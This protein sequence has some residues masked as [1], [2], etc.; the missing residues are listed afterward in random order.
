MEKS[1]RRYNS[2]YIL[3]LLLLLTGCAETIVGTRAETRAG[4][5]TVTSNPSGATIHRTAGFGPY[6]LQWSKKPPFPFRRDSIGVMGT[7]PCSFR[8][9]WQ[10]EAV[11]AEWPDGIVSKT[12][13]SPRDFSGEKSF[14]FHFERPHPRLFKTSEV[15]TTHSSNGNIDSADKYTHNS[16]SLPSQTPA[17]YTQSW[18]VI[19]GISRYAHTDQ[20]GLNNLIF[21]DDDAKAFARSLL[22]LGW[23][24]SHIKLLINKDAS[25][26]NIE[27]A[28]ESWLTKARPND[29]VILF[30]AGHG[31][32]DPENQEK[33]YFATYDTDIFIPATGYRMDKV[34]TAL[35]EVKAKNVILL[36]DT[37]HAGKL[38]TRGCGSRGISIV[39]NINKMVR[40]RK[41]PKGW[42][43]MVGADTC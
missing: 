8:K 18:A 31:Y 41:V 19:V 40:E 13:F 22:N 7:T 2:A 21:A 39:P 38:I 28:L 23:N 16:Q 1:F 20:N 35:E 33:V 3:V 15:Q 26:R 30:W 25:K 10:V 4:T 43:F 36:A 37:C 5:I 32:P 11:K 27:I 42:I 17:L 9:V 14:S 34:R 29:Q 12:Q 6:R 24:E